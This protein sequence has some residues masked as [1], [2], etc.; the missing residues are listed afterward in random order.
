M[1][2][3]NNPP[4]PATPDDR[5]SIARETNGHIRVLARTFH[6]TREVG[7]FCE[8]GCMGLTFATITEYD[9]QAGAWKEGHKLKQ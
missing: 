3:S 5:A 6:D 1:P 9:A 7:F 2:M 8:C 4:R